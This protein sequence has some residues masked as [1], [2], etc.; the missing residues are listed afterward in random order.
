MPH[1]T[2]DQLLSTDYLDK[3]SEI[4]KRLQTAYATHPEM[5]FLICRKYKKAT[6]YMILNCNKHFTH[7]CPWLLT[8]KLTTDKSHCKVI[9][10]KNTHSHELKPD[11]YQNQI[12]EGRERFSENVGKPHTEVRKK[13]ISDSY[14]EFLIEHGPNYVRTEETYANA[15]AGQ[16][17]RREREKKERSDANIINPILA[18]IPQSP[19][20]IK[21][22]YEEGVAKLKL[23]QAAGKV[24]KVGVSHDSVESRAYSHSHPKGGGYTHYLVLCEVPSFKAGSELEYLLVEGL[25]ELCKDSPWQVGNDQGG[26]R[27]DLMSE[28]DAYNRQHLLPGEYKNWLYAVVKD[29]PYGP[30]SKGTLETY[31]SSSSSSSSSPSPVVTIKPILKIGLREGTMF[32]YVD[33]EDDDGDEEDV[34][35]L[36]YMVVYVYI[37]LLDVCMYIQYIYI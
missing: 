1:F 2:K 17:K 15:R 6:G 8:F 10:F 36:H 21:Q 26:G 35:L 24:I 33:E 13:K 28:K 30:H 9:T 31:F 34:S 3:D 37:A 7:D 19:E 16:L 18:D 11:F 22:N 32:D 29:G 14:I 25:E 23:L 27:G 20:Q 5:G 4:Y 12:D